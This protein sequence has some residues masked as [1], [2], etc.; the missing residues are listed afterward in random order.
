MPEYCDGVSLDCP[1]DSFQPP[2][3][4]CRPPVDG[5]DVPEYCDG[6]SAGCGD[7]LWQPEGFLC[8]PVYGICDHPDF[9]DGLSPWCGD[10]VVQEG[11]PGYGCRPATDL[12][13]A[14]EH[15]NGEVGTCPD[16]SLQPP[17][18]ECRASTQECDPAEFCTGV[19]ADCPADVVSASAAVGITVRAAHN[20][21]TSTTTISWTG[22]TRPGPFNVYRGWITPETPW[23]WNQ[24]CLGYQVA[25]T[26]TDDMLSPSD[27][28]AFF[29]LVTRQEQNCAESILGLTSGGD[30]RPNTCPCPCP[31]LVVGR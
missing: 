20:V 21:V 31:G 28:Q 7:D 1:A 24:G 23:S 14:P 19:A 18:Y 17:S 9:C 29:Y 27:G 22:E 8:R 10:S 3:F 15:C 2:D 6:V 16:D 13:D 5:C 26:S 4:A 12:C 30:E 25:G 11:E